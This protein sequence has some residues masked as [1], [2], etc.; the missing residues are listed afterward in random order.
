MKRMI[1]LLLC[2][3]LLLSLA[4]CAKAAGGSYKL[5]YITADGLRIPPGGF[6]LNISFELDSDGVGTASYGSTQLDITWVDKGGSVEI[7]GPNGV[8]ELT[9][10]G[11][12]LILHAD[13]TLLFFKPVEEDD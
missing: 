11:E 5:E 1:T 3:A 4:G 7:T 12:N 10:D 13:G 2:A 6:G 8:L 9:K